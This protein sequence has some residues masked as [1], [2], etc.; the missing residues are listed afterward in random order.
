[1]RPREVRDWIKVTQLTMFLLDGGDRNPFPTKPEG[2]GNVVSWAIGRERE[3]GK[4]AEY[5]P[6]HTRKTCEQGS[7]HGVGG[8]YPPAV[9]LL[10]RGI[11][12]GHPLTRPSCM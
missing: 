6:R 5:C 12:P 10:S 8:D 9:G 11:I 2:L 1:M 4:V 7:N 3:E